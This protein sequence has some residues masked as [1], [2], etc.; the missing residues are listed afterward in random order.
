MDGLRFS[1]L[2]SLSLSVPPPPSPSMN[3]N[4]SVIALPL[5]EQCRK[6]LCEKGCLVLSWGVVWCWLALF[7][8]H[9]VSW[10]VFVWCFLF[11]QSLFSTSTGMEHARNPNPNSNP[12]FFRRWDWDLC[13]RGA[14]LSCHFPLP[15]SSIWSTYW[16]SSSDILSQKRAI[17]YLVYMS[18]A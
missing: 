15:L 14:F 11:C 8:S 16:A 7:L 3:I 13:K 17:F 2:T 10:P 5:W 9:L 1:H 6:V 12:H 4:D 18:P